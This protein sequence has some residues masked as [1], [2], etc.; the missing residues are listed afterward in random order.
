VMVY[1][2]NVFDEES[3]AARDSGFFGHDIAP[4]QPRIAGVNISYTF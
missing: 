3:F 1:L 4:T 2:E